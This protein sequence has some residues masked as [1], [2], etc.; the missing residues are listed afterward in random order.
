M[1]VVFDP[2]G[3][4]SVVFD[5]SG[6]LSVVFDLSGRLSVVFDLSGRLSVVFDLS[7]RLTVVFGI[8]HL[9][10][11]HCTNTL[12]VCTALTVVRMHLVDSRLANLTLRE[13]LVW[14]KP[15]FFRCE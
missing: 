4:L 5:L 12:L 7:G 6:R 13:L 14:S 1:S 3:R 15:V 8:E 11:T 10:S 2:S 9:F